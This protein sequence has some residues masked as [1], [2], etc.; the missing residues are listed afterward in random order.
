MKDV[1]V[2]FNVAKL[3]KEKGFNEET[4]HFYTKPNSKIF[5]ID[6]KNRN[7]LIKNIPKKLYTFG[8]HTVLRIENLFNAPSQ[9][10][11]QKWLRD[12]HNLHI[13]VCFLDHVFGYFFK[14]TDMKT[15]TETEAMGRFKIYEDALEEAL[16][17][18]LELL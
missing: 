2:S 17:K 15:N 4:L 6:E 18:T 14:I 3:A 10:I 5:G 13:D 8:E 11:L 9:S 16:Q 1:I 7:Y 12:V